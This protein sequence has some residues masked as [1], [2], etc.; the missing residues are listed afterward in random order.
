MKGVKKGSRQYFI[1]NRAGIGK[2]ENSN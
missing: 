1:T 2:W